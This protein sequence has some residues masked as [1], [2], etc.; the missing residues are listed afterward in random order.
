MTASVLTH[1]TTVRVPANHPALP[2]HFP[3]RP[4]VPGVVLLDCVLDSA[5]RWLARPLSV[6][7]LPVA[8]FTTPLMPEQ[9]ARMELT[10]SA[11]ELRF[12]VA[13]GER[14][15]EII[16]SGRFALSEELA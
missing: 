3:G 11:R 2:G 10:L 4:I 8:K 15:D 16:A 7:G 13:T 12:A 9:T 1:V 14:P 5:E 6:R